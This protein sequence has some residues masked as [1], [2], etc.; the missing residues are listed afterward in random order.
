MTT[1]MNSGNWSTGHPAV[2]A[3]VRRRI[4]C[5]VNAHPSLRSLRPNSCALMSIRGFGI[6]RACLGGASRRRRQLEPVRCLHGVHQSGSGPRVA[7]PGFYKVTKAL[8]SSMNLDADNQRITAIK[9]NEALP[10]VFEKV[11]ELVD[12]IESTLMLSL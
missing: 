8:R 4:P 1:V 11:T 2:A 10:P 12:D 3:D 6:L 9:L 5:V 7:S